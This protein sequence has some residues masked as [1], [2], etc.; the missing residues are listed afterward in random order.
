MCAIISADDDLV[1]VTCGSRFNS[2]SKGFSQLLERLPKEDEIPGSFDF[3]SSKINVRICYE[4]I[5]RSE[6]EQEIARTERHSIWVRL[7]I[8]KHR[9]KNNFE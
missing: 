1:Q 2:L 8:K 9:H 3:S 4:R 7:D 5:V 6:D